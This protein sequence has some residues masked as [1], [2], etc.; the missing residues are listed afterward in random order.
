MRSA[1]WVDK[2]VVDPNVFCVKDLKRICFRQVLLIV[3]R[4]RNVNELPI[5]EEAIGVAEVSTSDKDDPMQFQHVVLLVQV[6]MCVSDSGQGA[7][8]LADVVGAEGQSAC[9][10]LNLCEHLGHAAKVVTAMKSQSRSSPST[11]QT[12]H[13]RVSS[14]IVFISSISDL[15]RSLQHCRRYDSRTAA[16][17]ENSSKQGLVFFD[18]SQHGEV[19]PSLDSAVYPPLLPSR[20]D[21]PLRQERYEPQQH[22]APSNRCRYSPPSVHRSPHV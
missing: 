18:P 7:E 16:K 3:D 20:P 8:P 1:S 15:M 12:P 2:K 21:V 5:E 10:N 17:C 6:D 22:H 9:D 14:P 11:P 19:C 4:S 13:G